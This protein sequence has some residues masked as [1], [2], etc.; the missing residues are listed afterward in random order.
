MLKSWAIVLGIYLERENRELLALSGIPT[1]AA[2]LIISTFS[3]IDKSTVRL[4]AHGF[5]EVWRFQQPSYDQ[6]YS[7][8]T[9]DFYGVPININDSGSA[10][11]EDHAE[12]RQGC[13][14]KVDPIHHPR[15][16]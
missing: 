12:S 11:G 2:S 8:Y 14:G 7:N 3:S 15:D 1:V 6:S 9:N 4:L 10:S 5:G 13:T 16:I